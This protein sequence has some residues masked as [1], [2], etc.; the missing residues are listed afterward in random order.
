MDFFDSRN[1]L[2]TMK[3]RNMIAKLII[4]D[5]ML[6]TEHDIN[7]P[8][9]LSSFHWKEEAGEPDC[10]YY[11]IS[12]K[13][14][15]RQVIRRVPSTGAPVPDRQMLLMRPG[16]YWTADREIGID[17]VIL[18]TYGQVNTRLKRRVYIANGGRA[19]IMRYIRLKLIVRRESQKYGP[20]F[21]QRGAKIY[22][23]PRYGSLRRS[24]NSETDGG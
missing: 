22:M 6:G 8:V 11:S 17:E 4:C 7:M 20:N 5:R 1:F 9:L 19:W 3:D 10:R 13:E 24:A 23:P 16:R 12:F 2:D 14:Y 15:R 21:L 18:K